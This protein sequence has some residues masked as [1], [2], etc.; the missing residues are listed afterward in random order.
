MEIS[1]G[2]YALNGTAYYG[3]YGMAVVGL[4]CAVLVV[5]LYAR[6]RGVRLLPY[7]GIAA[8]IG[9]GFVAFLV[10]PVDYDGQAAGIMRVAIFDPLVTLAATIAAAAFVLGL[11]LVSVGRLR[12]ASKSS[13][14]SS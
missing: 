8:G 10:W 11:S 1:S 12:R 2:H 7:L 5:V 4:V 3:T 9:V 6:L 13:A 14:S